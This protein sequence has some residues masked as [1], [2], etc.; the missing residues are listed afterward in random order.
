MMSTRDYGMY[1]I[2]VCHIPYSVRV[3]RN[4]III[5]LFSI[6]HT[7]GAILNETMQMTHILGK[8]VEQFWWHVFAYE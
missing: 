2:H 3:Q 8:H 7:H 1:Y 4:R 6:N 5:S